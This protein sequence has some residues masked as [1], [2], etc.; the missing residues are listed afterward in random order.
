MEEQKI[1]CDG[2]IISKED[3]PVAYNTLK[4]VL[5]FCI[6]HNTNENDFK[7]PRIRMYYAL[8][9]ELNL[10]CSTLKDKALDA[11]NKFEDEVIMSISTFNKLKSL[12][13]KNSTNVIANDTLDNLLIMYKQSI[14][15]HLQE[16]GLYYDK[17]IESS[18]HHKFIAWKVEKASQDALDETLTKIYFVINA[19]I[20]EHFDRYDASKISFNVRKC[21]CLTD[22]DTGDRLFRTLINFRI[23]E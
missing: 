10:H 1:I 15:E 9:S 18:E 4:N 16:S 22:K 7:N 23:N 12:S 8:D 17:A 20:L 5:D 14:I 21:E 3:N 6:E 11:I 2:R 13:N 19:Y